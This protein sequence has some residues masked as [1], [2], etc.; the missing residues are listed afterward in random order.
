[1]FYELIAELEQQRH[2]LIQK[3]DDQKVGLLH[4]INL[5]KQELRMDIQRAAEGVQQQRHIANT[6]AQKQL[7]TT[8]HNVQLLTRRLSLSTKRNS[9][10]L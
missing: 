9:F 8:Q 1:M 6:Q 10:W 7:T 2:H 5:T 3:V 4:E